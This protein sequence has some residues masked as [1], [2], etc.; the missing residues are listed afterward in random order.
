MENI[1]DKIRL[2]VKKKPIVAVCCMP[3]IFLVIFFFVLLILKEPV[4]LLIILG[5]FSII[6]SL[7]AVSCFLIDLFANDDHE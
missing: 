1:I 7:I 5:S 6:G 2:Q 3:I 4:V